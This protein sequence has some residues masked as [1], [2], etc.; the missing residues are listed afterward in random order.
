MK[1]D[2]AQFEKNCKETMSTLDKLKEKLHATKSASS[3]NNLSETAKGLGLDAMDKSLTSIN[4]KMSVLG[5]AGATVISEMTKSAMNF[6]KTVTTAVPKII[7]EG[8]WTRAMN[9]EQAKF[10][11][12]GLGIAWAQVGE[13]I[14]NAVSGTA[15]SM[16]S[17]AKAASQLAASGI[18][19]SGVGDQMERTLKAISGVA[20]QTNSSYDE[21]ANIFT[22]VAG[23]GRLM[24]DQLKQLS[25][26]GMNAA[27]ALAKA[28]GTTEE[29][30]RDMVSKGQI[31]FE[32]FSDIMFETFGE[33]AFK[34]NQTFQGSLDNMKAALKRTGEA[35]AG[36]IIRQTIPVFNA[37]RQAINKANKEVF[38]FSTN[39]VTDQSKYTDAIKVA[40]ER[41]VELDEQFAAGTIT[42]DE[43]A[44][45]T[46]IVNNEIKQ[47]ETSLN[48]CLGPF[49][50]VAK[51]VQERIVGVIDQINFRFL[52]RVLDGFVNILKAGYSVLKPLGQAFLDVFGIS[53]RGI[54]LALTN[55]SIRFEKFT[56]LLILSTE[57]M[58]YLKRAFR[59]IISVMSMFSYVIKS[60]LAAILGV[61][62]RTMDLRKSLLKILGTIGD[63]IYV[64]TSWIKQSDIITIATKTLMSVIYS[65]VGALALAIT[66]VGDFFYYISQT[67]AFQ[68]V[69]SILE[70]TIVVL[71]GSVVLLAQKIAYIFSELR[72]GNVSVLG[73][74]AKVLEFIHNGITLVVGAVGALLE[75][76]KQLPIVTD[77]IDKVTAAF[78]KLR[79]VVY[80][81]FG[82]KGTSKDGAITIVDEDVPKGLLDTKDAIDKASDS[83]EEA[84]S[85]FGYFTNV[86]EKFRNSITLSRL[87]SIAFV[88]AIL[89][90]AYKTADALDKFGKGVKGIGAFMGTF[91]KK[92]LVG[93]ILG[94]GDKTPNKI[95]DTAIALGVLTIALIG[96]ANLPKEGLKQATEAVTG[97]MVGFTAMMGVL[98]YLDSLTGTLGGLA[99]ITES[100]LKVTLAIGGLAFAMSMFANMKGSIVKGIIGMTAAA[101]ELVGI[102]ILL[103]K[104]APTFAVASGSLIGLAVSLRIMAGTFKLIVA[105]K[106]DVNDVYSVIIAFAVFTGVL[107]GIASFAQRL[108]G[109]SSFMR[110]SLSILALSGSMFLI[111]KVLQQVNIQR[112]SNLLDKWSEFFK[113]NYLYFL[114]AVVAAVGV[115]VIAFKAL[116]L[117]PTIFEVV[118][119]RLRGVLATGK[120]VTDE[121]KNTVDYIGKALNKLGVAAI[122]L[123]ATA[124]IIALTG[125]AFLMSKLVKDKDAFYEGLIMVGH[126]AVLV[127]MLMVVSKATEKAKPSVL[128]ASIMAIGV[129]LGAIMAIGLMFEGDPGGTIKGFAG[130][131]IIIGA[132]MGMLKLMSMIK[133]DESSYK[134]IIAS[135]VG[136]GVIVASIATLAH[137]IETYGGETVAGAIAG[138][139]SVMVALGVFLALI[140]H[141]G[142]S[143][144]AQK[145]TALLE[146][147]AAIGAIA[148]SISLMAFASQ[149][150]Y[151]AITVS[152][153]ALG[154]VLAAFGIISAILGKVDWNPDTWKAFL[155]I[156]VTAVAI[157]GALSLLTAVAHDKEQTMIE[158]AGAIAGV[159]T[160]LAIIARVL[161]D[162]NSVKRG[163]AAMLVASVFA[164]SIAGSLAILA[165]FQWEQIKNALAGLAG[166]ATILFMVS[167]L[168]TAVVTTGIGAL[169][170]GLAAVLALS[171]AA[172]AAACSMLVNS[173]TA[174]VPVFQQFIETIFYALIDNRDNIAE[175]GAA[176][177]PFAGGLA[178]VGLAGVVLALGSAGLISGSVGIMAVATAMLTMKDIQWTT[179]GEGIK[180]IL[181]PLLGLGAI[182][183]VLGQLAPAMIAG[184]AALYIFG[185]AVKATVDNISKNTLDTLVKMPQQTYK[186]GVNTIVGLRNGLT[187]G[188]AIKTLRDTAAG[189]ANMVLSTI[190]DVMGIHSPSDE[191]EYDG[192]MA[193][194][195][196]DNGLD[197]EQ[198]WNLMSKNLEGNLDSNVLG[199]FNSVADSAGQAGKDTGDEFIKEA[200]SSVNSGLP[201]LDMA[202][203]KIQT[204]FNGLKET[205]KHINEVADSVNKKKTN[206]I[207]YQNYG[208]N[209]L[210]QDS[211]AYDKFK[212]NR[213]KIRKTKEATKET[214]AFTDALKDL[215]DTS[216]KTGGSIKDT[217]DKVKDLSSAFATTEK[218]SKVSLSKMINNL[219]NNYKETVNWAADINVLMSKGLDKNIT[220]WIKQMGVGG[221]E[222]VKAFMNATG[223]EVKLLNGMLPEY[224]SM[225]A[226]AQ[227]ILN[228][229]YEL[230]ATEAMRAYANTLQTYNTNLE[231]SVQNA[232]DPFGKFETKTEMTSA[233]V[234][235][236]MQSQLQG[237]RQWGDNVN[238]L[239]GRVS[240]DI[241]QY[242]YDLGPQSYDL[243]NAMAH[244]TD[245][246]IQTMNELYNQQLSIGKEIAI[247]NAEKYREVGQ[248]IT[249]GV[250]AGLDFTAIGQQGANIGTELV[251]QTKKV[252]DINSPS[253]VYR[254]EIAKR[255]P[256]G[257]RDGIKVYGHIAY[258]KLIEFA[259]HCIKVTYD[260]VNE[261]KGE[262]IGSFLVR[263]LK[264]GI[265]SGE[266]DVIDSISSLCNKIISRAESIFD[267]RSPSHVFEKIGYFLP[268]GA[269]I[270]VDKGKHELMSSV[271]DMGYSVI[272]RMSE[273]IA[274]ISENL[275]NDFQTISPV[276]TPRVDLTELQN[277][278]S[279]IDRMF[280]S[281]SLALASTLPVVAPTVNRTVSLDPN[282][283]LPVNTNNVDVVSA[284][285][286]LRSD[287]IGMAEELTNLQVVLDGQTLVGELAAPLD[288][289]LGQR[290]I[291]AGRRN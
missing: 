206:N 279:F 95:L 116:G 163:L 93:M 120:T 42:Q 174:F 182:S 88:G 272:D 146:M 252:L 122:I 262:E 198:L 280:A 179:I 180:S 212:A 115:T 20:A 5:I 66:K 44:E 266:Q 203:Y 35:F 154:G 269:A 32:Q 48:N 29:E 245:E 215:G 101:G 230:A 137:T 65:L 134:G 37:L 241:L 251:T 9:I 199:T 176:L 145:R 150:D 192:V 177:V 107:V 124:A 15:Y 114:G 106:D 53:T 99:T 147:I 126:V 97:L 4:K 56:K 217:A 131:V 60:V 164:L 104:F 49:E 59:G 34:A 19:I 268:K 247:K 10:Q 98:T 264:R 39:N 181:L 277:G 81:L 261:E 184:A 285:N 232:L 144:T 62:V 172:I 110:L 233:Q 78:E 235:E 27:A 213:D 260:I 253:G 225:D 244:M 271:D 287:M 70:K 25:Y 231:E 288:N 229:K 63:V 77:V 111:S 226:K 28:M 187:D 167:A 149:G 223:E 68:V 143:I 83:A 89:V 125:L 197:N 105:M 52:K 130:L 282:Q 162:G 216:K 69:I 227:D 148:A 94:T 109:N 67:K 291:R 255:L 76:V 14:N 50:K 249:D 38:N 135:I 100:M 202:I 51:T 40:K 153:I 129:I 123:S 139:G 13:Q 71:V 85:K 46:A 90:I 211:E 157:G 159:A 210:K 289:E 118:V 209:D 189:V 8:G 91:A 228:G 86:L 113:N 103:S 290:A 236:N 243:V 112:V 33:N 79:D 7:K 208:S 242:I 214:N 21:I 286:D 265:D 136:V 169:A 119:A 140:G 30:I 74:L 273:V 185:S 219:A 127:G 200:V 222:T 170:I 165:G 92:G 281:Q 274:D 55:F 87:A 259:N 108:G 84:G 45:K 152:A 207:P 254:D 238:S 275:N 168:M 121:V 128:L 224:L 256:E 132:W 173:L 257:I 73:P 160:I 188:K 80:E 11:L 1:F 283:V 57:E 166:A 17:A 239:V 72:K 205:L 161:S 193:L 195:G 158:A 276:I 220:D 191:T 142:M 270:G 117:I 43:Y 24:G 2:N 133:Y 250:I 151:A 237:M 82:K 190:R 183:T 240:E 102:M 221:H 204:K 284:I 156:A 218:Q 36:P 141:K 12:E 171:F 47:L 186:I 248:G 64:F 175:T 138:L 258:Q 267:E 201:L 246:Q 234:L 41:L 3:L 196:L 58:D 96:I 16:D 75:H 263:G 61:D 18:E 23:N 194:L 178:A 22:T 155:G 278:R 26:R 6:A 54:N 31:S